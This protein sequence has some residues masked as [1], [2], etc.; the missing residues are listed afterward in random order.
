MVADRL[1]A[2]EILDL[3]PFETKVARKLPGC[4][5]LAQEE[6][7]WW[8]YQALNQGKHVIRL[9]IGDPM[10]FGRGGEEVIAFR[11]FGV[12][13]V[14]VP[15]VSAA[16][17]AP[18]L[19]HIPVTHRGVANQVVLGTGYGRDGTSPELI[20][21]HK[22]QTVVFLMAVGRL[23]EL[24]E[25][26]IR[27]A[28]YPPETPVAIV[29]KAGCFQQQRTLMG[30][31]QTI[32]ALAV[33]HK[34]QPPSTIVVGNVVHVLLS[35]EEQRMAQSKSGLMQDSTTTTTVTSSVMS[36][37]EMMGVAVAGLVQTGTSTTTEPLL[38]R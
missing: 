12:N 23:Q 3:I 8:C 7:Y 16:V 14:I 1:V 13:P 30:N 29:E 21:Y 35:E 36:S 22:E 10:V 9:K 37:A 31:L 20:Q 38:G 15:G 18:L 6:I 34:I 2:R 17:A 28:H 32:A 27:L 4:A 33:Q 26:L 19:A 5:E 24:C 25:K 11:R